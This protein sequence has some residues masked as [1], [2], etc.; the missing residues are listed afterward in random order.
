MGQDVSASGALS[1]ACRVA[2]WTAVRGLKYDWTARKIV[3]GRIQGWVIGSDGEPVGDYSAASNLWRRSS[4]AD[5]WTQV[6]ALS[7]DAYGRFASNAYA[8]HDYDATEET[9]TLFDYG[10]GKGISTVASTGRFADREWDAWV[11]LVGGTIADSWLLYLE[12][13]RMLLFF[14]TAD[15]IHH[16]YSQPED[17][18]W[19]DA[20]G[21]D[22]PGGTNPKYDC[23]GECPAAYRDIR[24][25]QIV[26]GYVDADSG[27]EGYSSS[28]TVKIRC[29]TD[30]GETWGDPVSVDLGLDVA[31]QMIWQ[32]PDS[33]LSHMV[34]VT[35]GDAIYHAMS[36]DNFVTLLE[37][38]NLVT[39]EGNSGSQACGYTQRG[40][41]GHGI[42][43][44]GFVGTDGSYKQFKSE[45]LGKTWAE[46][47]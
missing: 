20:S 27:L 28:G 18:Y 30:F 36:D 24:H 17:Q 39:T 8:T 3:Q 37:T 40:A 41:G 23:E 46:V 19:V 31:K 26:L 9:S 45:D 15:S 29:S 11:V 6:E 38:P 33:G 2:Q 25:G 22:V 16:I 34:V 10:I 13:N 35:A 1:V 42:L 4:S 47:A 32:D 12:E 43:Y 5:D 44:V 7:S 21:I 14:F